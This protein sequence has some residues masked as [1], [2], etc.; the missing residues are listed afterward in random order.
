MSHDRP[1]PAPRIGGA[2]LPL[3][4][5]ARMYVCGTT[6]LSIAELEGGRTARMVLTVLALA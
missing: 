4:S 6:A 1:V 2:A 5:P 3:I